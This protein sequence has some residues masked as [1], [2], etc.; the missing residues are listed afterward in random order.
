MS[1]QINIK[2]A[3]QQLDSFDF[4]HLIA[5]LW[6]HQGWKTRVLQASN[7][8]GID[9]VARRAEPFEQKHLIQAK[10]YS[11]DNKVGSEEVQQYASLRQQED[12]VDA[13]IVVTTSGFTQQAERVA[14]D[15]NLKLID[16]DN[17]VNL[18]QN[19]NAID[20]VSNYVSVDSANTDVTKETYEGGSTQSIQTLNPDEVPNIYVSKLV[21]KAQG[22]LV[23]KNRLTKL[24]S[25]ITHPKT[26][27]EEPILGHLYKD[28]QPH[29]TLRCSQ[30][31]I[32][33]QGVIRPP[34][35]AYLVATDHRVLILIGKEN[36]DVELSLSFRQITG[37]QAHFGLA[38]KKIE[39]EAQIGTFNF[40]IS[41][42]V[43]N[44][45]RADDDDDIEREVRN[46]AQFIKE[47][48]Y[49]LI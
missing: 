37:V 14:T 1:E 17:L 7:D 2:T 27:T 41:H 29:Y 48:V 11:A 12:N 26:P 32:P 4:E 10:R 44:E 15:V 38:S 43:F 46:C 22:K 30:I 25:G 31:S 20:L 40:T 24:K 33:D 21:D 36:E 49:S 42:S 18:I 5:D 13:V 45:S 3:L 6:D 28:E 8:R 16:G 39:I 9:V 47:A 34:N 23:T 35:N 19:Q